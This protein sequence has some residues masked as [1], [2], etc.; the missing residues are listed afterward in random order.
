MGRAAIMEEKVCF[1][2]NI[3]KHGKARR[4]FFRNVLAVVGPLTLFLL[5]R[6]HPLGSLGMGLTAF[7][8]V[9]PGV[10]T[11]LQVTRN[12]CAVLAW[13]GAREKDDA[14]SADKFERVTDKDVD[15]ASRQVANSILRDSAIAGVIALAVVAY[16]M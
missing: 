16:L 4:R 9:F 7:F 13:K 15:R 11:H 14:P 12:T 3:N 2:S 5:Y 6:F 10:F 1:R 8:F